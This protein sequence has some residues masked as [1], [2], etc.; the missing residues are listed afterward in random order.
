MAMVK[1]ILY[2]LTCVICGDLKKSTLQSLW[3]TCWKS[4]SRLAQLL[5]CDSHRYTGH[6]ADAL[7]RTDP[8]IFVSSDGGY[9]WT[10]VRIVYSL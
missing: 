3:S 7:Q 5:L 6:V 2:T 9:S 4:C 10:Q 8:D 1:M